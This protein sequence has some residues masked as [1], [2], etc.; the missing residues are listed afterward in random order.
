RGEIRRAV[1]IAGDS[2]RG[3]LQPLRRKRRSHHSEDDREHDPF[4]T[5]PPSMKSCSRWRSNGNLATILA[6]RCQL[7]TSR[8][9]KNVR[10]GFLLS[11]SEDGLAVCV[12][13]KKMKPF[14][15]QDRLLR[16]ELAM[17]RYR[18]FVLVLLVP[19]FWASQS[20]AAPQVRRAEENQRG[21]RVCFYQ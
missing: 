6:Q 9:N 17:S 4:H 15:T 1:C 20:P 19:A 16:E 12:C 5:L 18:A 7:C 8:Q 14:A 13:N 3:I 11:R 2:R 21:A 10:F